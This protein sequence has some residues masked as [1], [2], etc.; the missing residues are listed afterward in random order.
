MWEMA[1]C[2]LLVS[3]CFF[4]NLFLKSHLSRRLCFLFLWCQLFS[5]YFRC[6]P[7]WNYIE[8]MS[9]PTPLNIL[10]AYAVVNLVTSPLVGFPDSWGAGHFPLN[11]PTV[12][13]SAEA[14]ILPL[15]L[16]ARLMKIC[17]ISIETSLFPTVVTGIFLC[18][19]SFLNLDQLLLNN[20]SYHAHC[21]HLSILSYFPP[22]LDQN[23]AFIFISSF[24]L[25]QCLCLNPFHSFTDLCQPWPL[26]IY[27]LALTECWML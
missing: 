9:F 1:R 20:G 24:F 5:K 10:V 17:F 11:C 23:S 12:I 19:L 22:L 4:S 26:H 15:L 16:F 3:F 25:Q 13:Q 8:Q 18:L 14:R 7:W 27:S 21:S 2:A 6:V